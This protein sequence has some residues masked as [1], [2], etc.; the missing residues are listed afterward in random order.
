MDLTSDWQ[1]IG[2]LPTFTR[3]G[4][5]VSNASFT[6]CSGRNPAERLFSVPE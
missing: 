4:I 1:P 3:L 5:S 2:A 6:C